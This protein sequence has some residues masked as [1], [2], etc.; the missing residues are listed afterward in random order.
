VEAHAV[1][2]DDW[3]TL[4]DR[5]GHT[6]RERPCPF[7]IDEHPFLE[8]YVT[9]S[10]NGSHCDPRG[11][12]GEWWAA[13]GSSDG[14]ERWVVDLSAWA[15]Q[16]VEV[17]LAVASDFS[18][19]VHGVF[20][21]DV[22]VS[23]GAGTTS[24]EADGDEFDGWTVPGAPDGSPGNANDWIVG[25]T[26]DT[27]PNY[28]VVASDSMER[29]GEFIAFMSETFGAYPF[30]ASGG[31]VDDAEIYYALE[32]QTRPIY[33]KYFFDDPLDSDSVFV[34]ELAHQWFGDSVAVQEWRHIWLNEGFATY[35]EWLWSE[36]EGIATAQELF[37]ENYAGIPEEDPFWALKIGDPGPRRLFD[38]A[39]YVRGAMTLH[40]LRQTIGDDAFFEVL[41]QWYAS[42]AGGHGRTGEFIALAEQVSGQD[43]SDLF[44]AWLFTKTKPDLTAPLQSASGAARWPSSAALLER[45]RA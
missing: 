42:Q 22:V 21:D 32:V 26:A 14:W 6:G 7:L 11:S 19:Q 40:E 3:T 15:G 16:R 29:Q 37:D 27:P 20:V 10:A 44:H 43:L 23:T 45:L 12:T 39:V 8:H 28:G 25:T 34:H 30:S 33:S 13:S 9:L 17:A 2:E 31:V 35:A 38:G 24:F 41:R 36:H 18:I 4:P 5:K 1:G